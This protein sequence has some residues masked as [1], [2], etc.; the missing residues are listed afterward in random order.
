MKNKNLLILSLLFLSIQLNATK[1]AG[2]IFR[3]GVGVR[4]FAIGHSGVTDKES[5]A[6]AYWNPAL[7]TETNSNFIEFMHAEEFNGL[8]KN[9][10]VTGVIKQKYSFVFSR[11]GIDDIAL[12]KLQNEDDSLSYANR[13]YAYKYSSN[14]DY[15]LYFGFSQKLFGID[16]GIAPKIAYRSLVENNGFGFGANIS[17]YKKLN[18]AYSIGLNLRDFFTSQIFW[19]NGTYET[20]YPSLDLENCFSFRIPV[21]YIPT[22]LYIG[23]EIY[24]ESREY[25]SSTN[26]ANFSIDGKIGAELEV[27]HNLDI[28]AGY[29]N[30]N[31][32][33]GFDLSISQWN[34]CYSFELNSE[35]D[36]SHR[37]ALGYKF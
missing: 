1:Y 6:I 20:V 8:L 29:Y 18:S 2:E 21:I 28:L 10:V 3:I 11:I 12:T 30:S 25:A 34:I 4:N 15:L 36:N 16:F 32:T 17:F 26:F 13:P 33:T 9:D 24:S 27:L 31:I 5:S 23:S 7:I 37:V 19:E 35:L 22:K 14:A